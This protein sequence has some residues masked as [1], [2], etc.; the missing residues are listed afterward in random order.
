MPVTS[1]ASRFLKRHSSVVSCVLKVLD[2]TAN[3]IYN[4]SQYNLL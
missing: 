3:S 4:F 1:Q 2:L